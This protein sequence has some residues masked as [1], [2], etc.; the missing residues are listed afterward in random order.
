MNSDGRTDWYS[1]KRFMVEA[2][3]TFCIT[4]FP[5]LAMTFLSISLQN[6]VSVAICSGSIVT[7]WAWLARERSG[8]HFN[9][10]LTLAYMYVKEIPITAG[11]IYM[12]SQFTGAIFA[13][14]VIY[15]QLSDQSSDIEAA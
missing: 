3:G 9:P 7:A 14:G 10:A 2:I 12:L 4:Y 15:F 13:G 6:A 5:W 8:G 1:K 11:L